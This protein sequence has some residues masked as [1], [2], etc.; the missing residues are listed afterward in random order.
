MD[1]MM[2]WLSF[3]PASST[4]AAK[5]GRKTTTIRK[6]EDNRACTYQEPLVFGI[7]HWFLSS[8]LG[9]ALTSSI[10]QRVAE[11]NHPS[12][13]ASAAGSAVLNVSPSPSSDT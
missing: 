12:L 8:S 3:A 6:K 2:N 13:T 9:I 11:F 10:A 4:T 5:V 7:D 1:S